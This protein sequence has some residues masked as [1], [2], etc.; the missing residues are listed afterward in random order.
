M[1]SDALLERRVDVVEVDVG[2]EA[3]DPRVDARWLITVHITTSGDEAVSTSRSASPR[4]YALALNH[5]HLPE[6]R[7]HAGLDQPPI[8]TP[9]VGDFYQG[10]AVT[11]Y[12][13]PR[14][15]VRP[16]GIADVHACLSQH[17]AGEHFVKVHPLGAAENLDSGFFDIQACNS[18]NRVDLFVFGDDERIVT[19]AR[20][21]NLGKGAA[22]AA[23]QCMNL[24]LGLDEGFGL[25]V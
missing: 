9:I 22:G 23:V 2:D 8:F 13:H 4:A 20:L 1:R 5:K 10:L 3:I 14:Q 25:T 12:W 11:T 17:Y 16:A 7:F 18:T 19:I 15:F 21:D 24:H 6:M